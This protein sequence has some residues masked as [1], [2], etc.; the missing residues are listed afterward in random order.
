MLRRVYALTLLSLFFGFLLIA[1]GP[2][3]AQ[4]DRGA[5]VGIVTDPSGARVSNAE[6]TITNR[7]TGQ[8][9]RLGPRAAIR[10]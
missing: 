6:V 10:A 4:V 3:A 2:A 7:D 5:I 1:S 9:I 8:P